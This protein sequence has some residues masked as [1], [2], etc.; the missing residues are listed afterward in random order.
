MSNSRNYGIDLLRILSMFFVVILHSLGKGGILD[1]V[2]LESNQYKVAWL[3]KI[4]SYCAVDIF[5]LISGYVSYRD[6]EVTI[7]YSNFFNLW[8]EALFYCILLVI[9]FM[10]FNPDSVTNNDLINM[11]LPITMGNYWYLNAYAGLFIVKPLLDKSLYNFNCFTLKKIFVSIIFV[12]SFYDVI[13]SKF[14][15]NRGYSFIWIVILYLLGAIMKKCEI[16]KNIKKRYL[17]LGIIILNIILFIYKIYGFEFLFL[18]VKITNNTFISYVSPFYLLMSIFYIVLFSKIRINN[19]IKKFVMF[20]TPSVFAIYLLNM[21]YHVWDNIFNNLFIGIV[22]GS[23]LK[24][25]CYVFSFSILF[26]IISI[27]IDKIRIKIFKIYEID[28]ISNSL[29]KYIKKII[30]LISN[31][32]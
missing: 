30:T 17:L 8:F 23:S 7:K 21:E 25:V 9:I 12:L 26:C 13:F 2:I 32:I 28:K 15:L 10:I 16:G 6:K 18:D 27:I 31:K 3:I 24:M 1:N 20:C 29:E 4:F 22:P 11:F 14:V 19:K 5:A